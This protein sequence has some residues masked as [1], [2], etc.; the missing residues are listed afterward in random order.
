[1]VL[2]GAVFMALT[3]VIFVIYGTCAAFARDRI[4]QSQTIMTWLNRSFAALFAGLG[5]RLAFERP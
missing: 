1:M 5:L 3:F 4:L 2:L